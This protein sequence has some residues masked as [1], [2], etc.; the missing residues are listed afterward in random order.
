MEAGYWAEEPERDKKKIS[1][2]TKEYHKV[3]TFK[4]KGNSN[5]ESF[6]LEE[7]KVKMVAKA[8]S[9]HY[10]HPDIGHY[11]AVRLESENGNYLSGAGLTI[12]AETPGEKS[13]QTIVRGIK[14][15]YY[16]IS[17]ISGVNWEVTIYQEK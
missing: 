1:H 13:S 15:G 17:V 9:Y 2:K 8:W 14:S 12:S 6:Y 11:S 5:S 16:Y 10:D 3:F 7:N 4:G